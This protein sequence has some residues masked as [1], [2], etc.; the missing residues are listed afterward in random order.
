MT[1][2]YKKWEKSF[3]FSSADAKWPWGSPG[4]KLAFHGI[5]HTPPLPSPAPL[6]AR[7]Y[8]QSLGLPAPN[9]WPRTGHKQRRPVLIPGAAPSCLLEVRQLDGTVKNEPASPLTPWIM[10]LESEEQ[11]CCGEHR[12]LRALGQGFPGCLE[13]GAPENVLFMM[14]LTH[15]R[16]LTT[17]RP[18]RLTDPQEASF[19]RDL[20]EMGEATPALLMLREWQRDLWS[21]TP[22]GNI[23]ETSTCLS[24]IASPSFSCLLVCICGITR[25]IS[26]W[27]HW[28]G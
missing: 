26:F 2:K 21:N 7:N 19:L 9:L 25:V 14:W 3:F 6:S 15:P 23:W 16:K 5:A 22:T 1:Q 8:R 10:P 13:Q 24:Q 12:R 20:C 4:S 28:A 27:F 17:N 11:P 18:H